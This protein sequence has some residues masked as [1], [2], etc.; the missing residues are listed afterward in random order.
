[1]AA[2]T[3]RLETNKLETNKGDTQMRTFWLSLLATGLLLVTLDAYQSTQMD[4]KL[5]PAPSLMEDG[6]GM[7]APTPTPR[8]KTQ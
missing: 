5:L 4:P 3:D 2:P 6:T 1:V 7:P 8:P